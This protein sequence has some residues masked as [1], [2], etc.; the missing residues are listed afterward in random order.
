MW[1]V[2][3][4]WFHM[5]GN[6]KRTRVPFSWPLSETTETA[7]DGVQSHPCVLGAYCGAENVLQVPGK[8]TGNKAKWTARTLRSRLW[9]TLC[10]APDGQDD[11]P[12]RRQPAACHNNAGWK[13]QYGS[14]VDP[15]TP[16]HGT[17]V[18]RGGIS[19]GPLLYR[20]RGGTEEKEG[21]YFAPPYK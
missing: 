4:Y 10:T 14:S 7:G 21:N 18:R 19:G 3:E 9:G 8:K 17:R 2:T 1:L 16:C 11:W 6:P 5:K 15:C 20:Q 12:S 13:L